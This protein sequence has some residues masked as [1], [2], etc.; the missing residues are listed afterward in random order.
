FFVYNAPPG[1]EIRGDPRAPPLDD[2]R[3]AWVRDEDAASMLRE[4][5]DFSLL[6]NG[7]RTNPASS[8]MDRRAAV[9]AVAN[10]DETVVCVTDFRQRPMLWLQPEE[11]AELLKMLPSLRQQLRTAERAVEELDEKGALMRDYNLRRQQIVDKHRDKRI[12]RMGYGDFRRPY[13]T[14]KV[15]PKARARLVKTTK[16][17][18]EDIAQR[19][20]E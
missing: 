5:E 1:V 4:D 19:G 9:K 15:G 11:W 13:E 18:L 8:S 3:P 16:E 12:G 17:E 14:G 10:G 6:G 2:V 7:R 20:M